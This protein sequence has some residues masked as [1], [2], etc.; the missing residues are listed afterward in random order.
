MKSNAYDYTVWVTGVFGRNRSTKFEG[1]KIAE[2]LPEPLSDSEVLERA[3][4]ILKDKKVRPG[5]KYK[6]AEQPLELK[7]EGIFTVKSFRLM[8]DRVI[9]VGI[10]T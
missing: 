4:K 2:D 10:V 6:I 9:K 8:S 3:E 5:A 1:F 7:K